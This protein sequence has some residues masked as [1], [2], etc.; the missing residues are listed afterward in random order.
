MKDVECKIEDVKIIRVG[1]TLVALN[2]RLKPPLPFL[3]L[4]CFLS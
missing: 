2:G 4:V 1:A 3:I